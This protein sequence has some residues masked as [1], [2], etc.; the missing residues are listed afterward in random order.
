MPPLPDA[1]S[2]RH[3]ARRTELHPHDAKLLRSLVIHEDT[4][5]FVLNKPAGLAVQG[6]TGTKRH[7]DGMLD[8]L[9]SDGDSRGS[10]IGWIA[11]PAA[12]WSS[13]GRPRP[14]VS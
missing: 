13:P 1:T 14:P 5:V 9:A 7:I 4:Q 8:A 10:A 6:G 2:A 11:T 3:P 12:S